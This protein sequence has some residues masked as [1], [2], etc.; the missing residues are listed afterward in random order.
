MCPVFFFTLDKREHI[1]VHNFLM[2]GG[3]CMRE[4][5]IIRPF[6]FCKIY[7]RNGGKKLTKIATIW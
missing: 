7:V 4:R 5:E 3:V 6:N 1:R 2:G